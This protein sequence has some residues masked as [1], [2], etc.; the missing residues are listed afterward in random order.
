MF[1]LSA[2]DIYTI[3]EEVTGHEPIIMDRRLLQSAV[4]RPF[5]RMFGHEPYPNLVDKAAALLHSLAHDHLFVDGNKRTAQQAVT[6]F[7]EANGATVEWAD[8]DAQTFIL[9]IAKGVTDVPDIAAWIAQN[10]TLPES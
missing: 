5:Q 9:E 10:T 3:N 8:A 6:R 4:A 1:F 7:L 2:A